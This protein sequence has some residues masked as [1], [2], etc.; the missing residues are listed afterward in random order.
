MNTHRAV[1]Q[2]LA[3]AENKTEL[4]SERVELANIKDIESALK[5]QESIKK[6]CQD[7]LKVLNK[8]KVAIEKIENIVDEA[9]GKQSAAVNASRKA[10]D[11]FKILGDFE[12]AAADLGLDAKKVPAYSKLL[13]IV[14]EVE[15]L[16]LMVE[17]YELPSI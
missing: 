1:R 3:K 16:E 2:F 8:A 7:A 4:K 17:D 9:N 14:Y 5:E 11:A 15:E 10:K 6:E 13:K 12:D